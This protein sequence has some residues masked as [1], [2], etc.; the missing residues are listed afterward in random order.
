M[1]SNFGSFDP[2]SDLNL[3]LL[4]NIRYPRLVSVGRF[5]N[6]YNLSAGLQIDNYC[7]WYE[8]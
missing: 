8:I 2:K 3:I 1:E 5:E 7:V 6:R 4:L